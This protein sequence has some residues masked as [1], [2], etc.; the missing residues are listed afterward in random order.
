MQRRR[1]A[2]APDSVDMCARAPPRGEML[3]TCA[4]SDPF[5]ESTRADSARNMTRGHYNTVRS[6]VGG[7]LSENN[8]INITYFA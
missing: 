2:A 5:R 1:A 7:E 3:T 6:L 4:G 8:I